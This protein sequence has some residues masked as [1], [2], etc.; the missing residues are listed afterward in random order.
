[1]GPTI[2]AA[3]KPS[4]LYI[5]DLE[6]ATHSQAMISPRSTEREGERE[7]ESNEKKRVAFGDS[8]WNGRSNDGLL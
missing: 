6:Q 5:T 1:M 7:R 3:V 2:I 4:S 8:R